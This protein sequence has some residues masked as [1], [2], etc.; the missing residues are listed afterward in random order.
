MAIKAT[1]QNRPGTIY[2]LTGGQDLIVDARVIVGST[3]SD[4]IVGAGGGAH[5]VTVFG[6]VHGLFGGIDLIGSG[7]D[8]RITVA[9][10]G[11]VTSGNGEAIFTNTERFTLLNA[12]TIEGFN[13]VYVSASGPGVARLTNEG[14]IF[15]EN[16]G[17]TVGAGEKSVLKN[18]GVIVG[19]DQESFQ[20]G[21]RR[22]VVINA[23]TMRGDITLRDGNDL[24]DGRSGL[25]FGAVYGGA[26]NDVFRPGVAAEFFS[27]GENLD[28]V[29]Y[30]SGGRV[31]FNLTTPADNAG[32]ARGDLFAGI[33]TFFGS[34][35]GGDI[36]QGDLL[37]QTFNGFGGRDQ[38]FGGSG[39]DTLIGGAGADTLSGGFESDVFAFRALADAGDTIVDFFNFADED[40]A[41]HITA[42]AFGGGMALGVLAA[43]RFVARTTNRA[44]D[45]GDRFIFET[46]ATRLWFDRD[47]N[48][49]GFAPVLIADL[50]AGAFITSADIVII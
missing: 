22:D 50:Q 33:E 8:H 6:R 25:L 2:T 3:T 48:G 4:A 45:A 37:P 11:V 16:R 17:V 49:R 28:V 35:A 10:G 13:G 27:G 47:G 7:A 26:G 31:V 15:G 19:V 38:L 24:Y 43:G 30:R 18:T 42:S 29:D 40:D 23:G 12:G 41:I 36:M 44:G 20:G 34:T 9:S 39:A 1:T 14:S 32:A 5:T 46:D 21:T